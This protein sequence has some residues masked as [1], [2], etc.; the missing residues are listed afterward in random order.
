[1][2]VVDETIGSFCNIDV[3]PVADVVITS[4]TKSFSG[5]ANVMG[6][7]AVL[8]PSS[9]HYSALKPIFEESFRNEYF[10]GDAEK[11]LSN[12]ADYMER[13]VILNRNADTVTA[14]LQEKSKDPAYGIADVLYPN[15]TDTSGNYVPFMRPTIDDF[16]PGYGCLFAVEFENLDLTRVFYDALVAYNGPHLGAHHTLAMPF[17]ELVYGRVPTDVEYHRSYGIR[18]EQIRVSVGLESEEDLIDT[19]QAALD[20]VK[21][22]KTADPSET[23]VG[24]ADTAAGLA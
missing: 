7:A 6:G 2:L 21:E 10:T 3:L 4:L 16:T 17:A 13:S 19:F 8:N 11:M 9:A 1:L 12:G 20:K 5:Y 15:M 18:G 14:F 24:S 22:V 23:A